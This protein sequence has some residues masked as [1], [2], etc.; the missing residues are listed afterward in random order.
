[1][2]RSNMPAYLTLRSLC[3]ALVALGG[4]VAGCD[5]PLIDDP[6]RNGGA[7]PDPTGVMTGTVLYVGARPECTRDES[8]QPIA[9]IGNVVLTLFAYDNPPPPSGSASS[10]LSLLAM[11]GE[12]MFSIADCMPLEPTDADRRPV[13]RSVPFTWPDLAL[14]RAFCPDPD[15]ANP[16]CPEQAY[17]VRGFYDYDGDFLP[18]YG[19]RNLPTAGD[20]GGGAFVSTAASPPIPLRIAFGHIDEHPEGQLVA[21]VA[22]TLGAVINTERPIFE[23]DAMT[24]AMDSAATLPTGTD[25]IAREQA[26]FAL[27]N[28]HVNAIVSAEQTT[29][30]PEWLAA[31]GAAG[32]DAS[33]YR[34]ADPRYGFY[35]QPVD[36]NLDGMGDPHPILGTAGINW[37]TPI[38]IT[39]RA[40]SI[41]EQQVGIPDVLIVGSI[42]PSRLAGIPSGIPVEVFME[43]DVAM[44]PIAVMVTNPALP[45][46]CRA[47]IIPPGNTEETYER[48]WVDCQELPTG[49][50]DVNVLSG[51][52]GA[53]IVDEQDRCITDCL[54]AGRTMEQCDTQCAFTVPATTENGWN[55]CSTVRSADPAVPPRRVCSGSYSGQ[56]WSIPND[57]GCP[58]VDY[59]IGAQNQLD[60]ERED[61][62]LPACGDE[63]SVMLPRQGRAGGWSIVDTVDNPPEEAQ[64]PTADGHGVAACQTATRAADGSMQP[65]AYVPPPNPA[66]CAASLDRFCGLPLCP[67]RGPSEVYPGAVAEGLTGSRMTREMR[68][69]GEDFVRDEEG[70]IVPLCTPFLMPVECCRIAD[71]C[72]ADPAACP[73]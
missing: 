54:A 19:A 44:P 48:I 60:P 59:R 35:I 4:L 13:M 67:L 32:M 66:C 23:L 18:F 41:I 16:H 3:V 22:V 1:M 27:T 29:P 49:N 9:V 34:F 46:E 55:H 6:R 52:A 14:G 65:V 58:D 25:P 70:G 21:G 5:D 38:I 33:H 36:A 51:L 47:P 64:M 43:F 24:R 71:T 40:R 69:E 12:S 30:A 7:A 42:R 72:A 26:L 63:G 28:M 68:I 73:R 62:S 39:R 53:T 20:V 31:L 37:Y 61:G 2:T 10:A 50:Y 57:L 56:A 17:Q 11:P 15:P 8:G 45:A